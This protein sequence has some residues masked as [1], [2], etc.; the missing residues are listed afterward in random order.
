MD[1]LY[2]AEALR[3][4]TNTALSPHRLLSG[5]SRF[6]LVRSFFCMVH[7]HTYLVVM[8]VIHARIEMHSLRKS[9]GPPIS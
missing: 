7:C 1:D 6:I 2:Q 9:V 4:H 5:D 3:E 8:L